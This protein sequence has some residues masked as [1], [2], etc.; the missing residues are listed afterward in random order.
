MVV[1]LERHGDIAVLYLNDLRR[2]NALS[3]ALV[4]ALIGCLAETRGGDNPARAIVISNRGDDFCAGADIKD[5]L[6][7]GWLENDAASRTAPTPVDLFRIIDRERRPVIAAVQGLVLGGGVEL[8]TV[9]DLVVAETSTTFRL[10][11]IGLGVLPNTALSRLPAI[12]GARRTAELIL[13]R[14]K[15]TAEEASVMGF[16]SSI[17]SRDDL[18]AAAVRMARSIIRGAP[19]VAIAGVK[20]GL[21]AD[22]WERTDR[23]LDL[24][25]GDEW[26]EGTSAF[27]EKR[28]PDYEQFWRTK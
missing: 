10:P 11:E 15:W 13:T 4:E 9:C 17:V 19:P 7:T 2:K 6:A 28:K 23:L 3:T 27:A 20:A 18:V 14:R 16:V 1:E 25:D 8:A 26:R 12:I 22:D 5:M 24:M 21:R